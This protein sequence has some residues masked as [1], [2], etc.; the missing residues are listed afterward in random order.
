MKVDPIKFEVLRNGFLE[1]TEEMALALR[2][3]AYSTNIKTRCDFS[4]CLFDRDL[5]PIAQSFSQP[6]HLGSMVGTVRQAVLEYGSENLGPGDH[7]VINY[8][9]HERRGGREPSG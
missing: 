6:N 7:L 9:Y 2:R 8:P 5:R 1:A 4:C 3:S